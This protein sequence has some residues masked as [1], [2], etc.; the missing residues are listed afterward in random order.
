MGGGAVAI[1]GL[2]A[3]SERALSRSVRPLA[4]AVPAHLGWAPA[5][6]GRA[7]QPAA[8]RPLADAGLERDA[9]RGGGGRSPG[10][11]AGQ[12]SPAGSVH[13]CRHPQ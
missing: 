1:L 10:G 6:A 5:V 11:L 8:K 2:R 4:T 12:G 13:G 9:R 7:D 3:A